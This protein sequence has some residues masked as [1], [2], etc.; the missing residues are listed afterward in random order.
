[1]EDLDDWWLVT[2]TFGVLPGG[3]KIVC[4]VAG[5]ILGDELFASHLR[6][7]GDR[8]AKT[9]STVGRTPLRD[10]STTV[11]QPLL[12]HVGLSERICSSSEPAAGLVCKTRPG[13]TGPRGRPVVADTAWT[14]WPCDTNKQLRFVCR[15]RRLGGDVRFGEH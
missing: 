7:D 15:A 1:M 11:L 3:V 6:M 8:G 14:M 4:A 9:R 13:P 5:K 2:G 10:S 12:T